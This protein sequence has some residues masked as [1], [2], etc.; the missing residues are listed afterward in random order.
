MTNTDEPSRE[1]KELEKLDL[2]IALMNATLE[3]IRE[4]IRH[5]EAMRRRDTI[6]IVIAGFTALVGA[7]AIGAAWV[8]FFG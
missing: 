1:T 2:E 3:K 6:K 7:F 8:T 4:D 5:N